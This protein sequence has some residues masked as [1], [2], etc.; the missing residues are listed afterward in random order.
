MDFVEFSAVIGKGT[1]VIWGLRK[2]SV[3]H[4]KYYRERKTQ[5]WK[6]GEIEF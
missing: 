6:V 3:C 1:A 5:V 2:Q 4:E